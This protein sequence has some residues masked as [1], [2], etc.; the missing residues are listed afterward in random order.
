MGNL[1]PL[2]LRN[3]EP[4]GDFITRSV[5]A[6]PGL[7]NK[8]L[9]EALVSATRVLKPV[10]LVRHVTVNDDDEEATTRYKLP[11]RGT[12][13]QT[14]PQDDR[15]SL[16][17]V[18]RWV[19][20]RHRYIGVQCRNIIEELLDSNPNIQEQVLKSFGCKSERT[21]SGWTTSEHASQSFW[22]GTGAMT[23]QSIVTPARLT[24][25][26][27]AQSLEGAFFT[28]GRMWWATLQNFALSGL[29]KGLRLGSWFP[30]MPWMECFRV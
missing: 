14:A 21:S 25:E 7:L 3:H 11:M 15:N 20:D 2:L 17:N 10:Q 12:Q 5:V 28:T 23:S 6:Y 8:A 13:D 29:T 18:Y 30:P 26:S 19:T 24:P 27:T 16:R 9:A 22:S 1:H 4:P